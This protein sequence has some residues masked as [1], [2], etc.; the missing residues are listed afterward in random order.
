MDKYKS[1]LK[2]LRELKDPEKA[3]DTIQLLES[4]D[5]ETPELQKREATE[6]A[7]DLI[8]ADLTAN[9]TRE[10]LRNALKDK[11]LQEFGPF[12]IDWT[13]TWV[14]F[15]LE[16]DQAWKA[17]YSIKDGK[18]V[19]GDAIKVIMKTI[20]VPVM[21]TKKDINGQY[22]LFQKEKKEPIIG[23]FMQ[24]IEADTSEDGTIPIKI[25]QPGWG[26]SGYYSEEV[27]ERDANIYKEGT[28]MYWNHPTASEAIERPERDLNDLAG[29]LV[30]EGIYNPDGIQGAGVYAKAKVFNQYNNIL[31]E[32]APHIG[33]SHIALGKATI[34]EAEGEKGT[35]IES[36]NLA[37]SVDFV[38]EEGAGGQVVQLFEAARNNKPINKMA[39]KKDGES[40]EINQLKESNTALT[41]E[42]KRLKE[43]ALLTDAKEFVEKA[44][45]DSELPDITKVRLKESLSRNPVVNNKGEMDELKYLETIKAEVKKESEYLASLSESG[46]ITGMGG[47]EPESDD[48]QLTESLVNSFENLGYSEDQ[49]KILVKGRN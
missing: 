31:S 24:L 41:D 9:D 16:S 6:Q 21:E 47:G 3:K 45:K 25:I 49:V 38:T 19:F 15:E 22:D 4:I 33:L 26:S 43:K 1:Y 5:T 28:K 2:K 27:L 7:I 40:Q 10:I 32:M 48:K 8:E 37:Q 39:E 46:K 18:V 35:I 12:I 30:E 42:L 23:D 20:P 44:L 36:L 17:D 11:H 29:V 34:G 14:V 13:D